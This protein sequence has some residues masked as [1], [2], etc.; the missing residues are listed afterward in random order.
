MTPDAPPP[1]TPASAQ[2]GTEVL[3][4]LRRIAPDIDPAS[5][6]RGRPMADQ[7]E[8]DSMDYQSL[9]AAIAAR[10]AIAI[11][12]SAVPGLRTIDDLAAFVLATTARQGG[13]RRA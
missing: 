10:Y 1:T 13:S 11:P 5:V 12:E 4:L 8:L 2:I 6:D 3:E 9:L 7:L